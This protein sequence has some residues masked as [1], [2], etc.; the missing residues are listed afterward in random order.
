MLAALASLTR[1]VAPGGLSIGARLFGGFLTVL[2]LTGV[3]ALVAAGRFST[4]STS[5]QQMGEDIEMVL[6]LTDVQMRVSRLESHLTHLLLGENRQRHMAELDA[7]DRDVK[8]A[9]ALCRNHFPVD[10]PELVL[11]DELLTRYATLREL[12]RRLVA[13]SDD[14]RSAEAVKLIGG[15]WQ[16]RYAEVMDTTARLL[17]LEKAELDEL[18]ATTRHQVTDGR[19]LVGLLTLV[20][21]PMSLGL[22]IVITRSITKPVH[23]LIAATER[24][25]NGDLQPRTLVARSDELGRLGARLQQM[26]AALARVLEH[27]RRFLTDASHELRTPLTIIRGEAEVALRGPAKPP[28]EYREALEHVLL[29]SRRMGR[30]VDEILF[31]ARS[32]AG[33]MPYRMAPIALGLLLED[34]RGQSRNLAVT[35][36]VGLKFAVRDDV[37]V[38][39]DAERLTQLLT[40]LVDNALNYTPP[41]GEVTVRLAADAT[42]AEMT[43]EDTGVGISAGDLPLIFERFYRGEVPA[44]RPVNGTGLGLAIA[45]AIV[46]AHGGTISATSARHRGSCFTVRLPLLAMA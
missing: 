3:L 2:L 7:L 32:G 4:V 14:G 46:E 5:A 1:R 45:K 25:A 15:D 36:G 29:V 13:M 24:A 6:L 37:I 16:R 44:P 10:A 40:I 43:V 9:V 41:G 11:H 42:T 20:T 8:T 33:E 21:I 19:W 27:Q 12:I 22:T 28:V 26:M 34:V 39:G 38:D 18:V 35:R 31:L 17:D 30:L 23:A